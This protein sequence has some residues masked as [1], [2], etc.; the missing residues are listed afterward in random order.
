KR[1]IRGCGTE[2]PT[3][4]SS[5]TV[6]YT[7]W[8]TDGKM[9]DSSVTRGSAA[10]FPLNRVIP[11]WTEGVQLM[12]VGEKRRFWIPG[13]LAYGDDPR[14]GAPAGMLVFDVELIAIDE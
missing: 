6:H 3:E 1:L 13:D 12:V 4:A 8:T 5:V 2:H 10:T 7:G 11:G 9:F 14:P